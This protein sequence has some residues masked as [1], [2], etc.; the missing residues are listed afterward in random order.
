MQDTP[1]PGS[2]GSDG[3]QSM[4]VAPISLKPWEIA[5][6]LL[7]IENGQVVSVEFASDVQFQAWILSHGVPIDEAGIPEWSFDDRCGVIM[8]ALSFGVPLAFASENNSNN[9]E[10]NTEPELFEGDKSVQEA[11]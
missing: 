2:V 4:K 3:L 10:K 1:N 5:E 11:N 7:P 8:H 6:K 9:S